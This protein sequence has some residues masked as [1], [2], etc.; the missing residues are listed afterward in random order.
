MAKK[1]YKYQEKETEEKIVNAA[2]ISLFILLIQLCMFAGNQKE[3]YF[4][5]MI[6]ISVLFTIK[7]SKYF[8]CEH[9]R[10]G[11]IEVDHWK[12]LEELQLYHI[13]LRL[14]QLRE[15]KLTQKI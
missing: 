11:D 6:I 3:T 9:C 1:K 10:W 13:K 14:N 2:I 12:M 5:I 7:F 4:T 15:A 8:E